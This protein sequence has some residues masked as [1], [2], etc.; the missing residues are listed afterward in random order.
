VFIH[1]LGA[2][3]QSWLDN[4]PRVATERRVLAIDLPGH[5][6][7]EM[8]E[9]DIS[10]SGFGRC[11]EEFCEA[12]DLGPVCVVGN[13][14]GGFVGAELAIVEPQRVDRLVLVGAAGI[15]ITSLRRAPTLT[16]MRASALVGTWVGSHVDSVAAR[17]RARY[18]V[19]NTIMRHPTRLA[20]DLTRELIHSST[21]VGAEGFM[22]TMEALLSY[23]FRDRLP[24]IGC[25]VLIVHGKEDM[26]VP[27][28]DAHEF[29]RLIPDARKV[30][31]DDTGH[32]PMI[33]RPRVFNDCLLEFLNEQGEARDN[34]R[35]PDEASEGAEAA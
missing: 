4:I 1:G 28:K 5:G 19:L 17:P 8:P 7:S 35:E 32:T 14:T 11:V 22:P 6:R 27:V 31:L 18:A 33:E 3:W 9:E 21:G 12:L 34:I 13:S 20:P 23:D 2:S 30:I 25:P 16:V 10:I 24:E 15:S 26:L 29:E